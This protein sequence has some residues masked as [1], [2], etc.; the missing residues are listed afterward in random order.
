MLPPADQ[1]AHGDLVLDGGRLQGVVDD[2]P[3]LR[4]RGVDHQREVV[5]YRDV[6]EFLRLLDYIQYCGD[7]IRATFWTESRW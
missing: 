2:R 3:E 5:H 7:V 4:F 6:D 1:E